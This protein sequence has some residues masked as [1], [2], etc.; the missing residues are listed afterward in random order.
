MSKKPFGLAVKA[1]VSDER[2]QCLLVKRSMKSRYY[3]GTWDLPGGK[4]DAGETFDD[5]LVREVAEETGLAILLTGVAGATEYDMP[6]VRVVVLF[7]EARVTSGQ[8]R[9]SD[10]HDA[11][12]WAPRHKLAD[13]DLSEQL[14]AFVERY[15]RHKGVTFQ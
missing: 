7:M 8:V 15:A 5:A 13:M 3:G 10:E 2:G 9:L 14:K 4:V 6:A 11:H 1:F 12:V